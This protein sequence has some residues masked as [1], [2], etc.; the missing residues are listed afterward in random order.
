MNDQV[1]LYI[2]IGA[3]VLALAVATYLYYWVQRQS[4]GSARAGSRFMD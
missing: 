4:A 3:G 1:W 2:A